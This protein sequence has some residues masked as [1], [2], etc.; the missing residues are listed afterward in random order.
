MDPGK[1]VSQTSPYLCFEN[2]VV[3]PD[4]TSQ[5]YFMFP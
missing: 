2:E 5:I 3:L 1:Q 4:Y